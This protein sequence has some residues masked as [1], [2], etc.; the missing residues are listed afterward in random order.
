MNQKSQNPIYAHLGESC[1]T[2]SAIL[3][4]NTK[5]FPLNDPLYKL[6]YTRSARYP[7]PIHTEQ[8]DYKTIPVNQGPKKSC[9][10]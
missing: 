4:S 8:K 7:G 3:T 6:Y 5:F 2:S 9:C 10:S 1:Q